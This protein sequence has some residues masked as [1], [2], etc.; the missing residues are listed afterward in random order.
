MKSI[1][2]DR[3]AGYTLRELE[4]KYHI[5]KSNIHK[6]L[7]KPECSEEIQAG[8]QNQIRLIPKANDVLK[9]TL[10]N[11]DRP[12]LRLK[13]ASIVFDNT[14]ISGTRT[15]SPILIQLTQVNN[16]VV[17]S[18]QLEQVLQQVDSIKAL[19]ADAE[20]IIDL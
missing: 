1:I 10:N 14:G 8:L 4:E 7:Q 11:I 9:E 13:A 5:D 18:P 16:T 17:L 2:Q 12:E 3:L 19:P 20:D 15:P 6:Q